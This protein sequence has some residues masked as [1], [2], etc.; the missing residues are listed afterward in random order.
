MQLAAIWHW[1]LPLCIYITFFHFFYISVHSFFTF[2]F[3]LVS[4]NEMERSTISACPSLMSS[5]H[6]GNTEG[7]NSLKSCVCVRMV[8]FMFA[9]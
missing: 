9:L 1:C 8:C 5:F 4:I 3:N 6:R 2:F 7:S